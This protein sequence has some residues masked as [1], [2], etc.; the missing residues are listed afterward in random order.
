[1][2]AI[3]LNVTRELT[4]LQP[5]LGMQVL[6]VPAPLLRSQAEGPRF[7][8]IRV[9]AVP[10]AGQDVSLT[11]ASTPQSPE[12]AYGQRALQHYAYP[13]G[14]DQKH[15]VMTSTVKGLLRVLWSIVVSR[16]LQVGFPMTEAKVCVVHDPED[17]RDWAVL[18][19]F[20]SVNVVQALAFWD[21]LEPDLQEWLG[22]L[23]EHER[24]TFL[25]RMS[26]RIHW[27]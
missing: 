4:D 5:G 17:E 18:R 1:M 9:L 11:G 3:S 26:M 13:P 2:V 6:A 24:T 8:D 16:A 25:S 14:I 15:A 19:V 20:A 21:S 7:D 10:F 23:T 22:G 12:T 27:R